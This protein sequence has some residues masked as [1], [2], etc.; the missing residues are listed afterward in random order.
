LLLAAEELGAAGEGEGEADIHKK[1]KEIIEGL[2]QYIEAKGTKS[3][4]HLVAG[5]FIYISFH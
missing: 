5:P 2:S 3:G 4:E 1:R